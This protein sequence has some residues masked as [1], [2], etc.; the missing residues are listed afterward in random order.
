ME[1]LLGNE[2]HHALGRYQ[3]EWTEKL[4][5]VNGSCVSLVPVRDGGSG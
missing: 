1:Q 3:D 5:D 4:S 2:S